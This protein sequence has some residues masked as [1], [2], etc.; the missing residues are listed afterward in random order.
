MARKPIPG[1]TDMRGRPVTRI[2]MGAGWTPAGMVR[3]AAP[4]LTRVGLRSNPWNNARLVDIARR[5]VD[6][7]AQ[8]LAEQL[9]RRRLRG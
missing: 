1:L 2:N 3:L 7:R 5:P 8:Q 9:M 6:P 4:L